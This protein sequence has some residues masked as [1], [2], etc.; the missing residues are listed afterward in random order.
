MDRFTEPS[1][2]PREAAAVTSDIPILLMGKLGPE[3]G[4]VA[5]QVG[6]PPG[7]NTGTWIPEPGLLTPSYRDSPKSLWA[8]RLSDGL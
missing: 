7:T 8:L 6:S 1:R 5:Q 4:T 2:Q 3:R